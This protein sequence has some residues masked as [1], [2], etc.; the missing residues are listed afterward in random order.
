MAL[1]PKYRHARF[2][3]LLT[4]RKQQVLTRPSYQRN[5]PSMDGDTISFTLRRKGEVSVCALSRAVFAEKLS[6]AF[7]VRLRWSYLVS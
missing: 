1:T 2:L 6:P 5:L 7:G 4:T 3:Y